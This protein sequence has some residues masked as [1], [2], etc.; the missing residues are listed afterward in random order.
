MEQLL[1]VL[2]IS[3]DWHTL[4]NYQPILMK[5]YYQAGLREL[6]KSCGF[7]SA[8]LKSLESCSNFKRTHCFL[9]QVWE[10]VY[11]EIIH[12][13]ISQANHRELISNVKCFLESEIQESRSP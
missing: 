13:Y 3:E 7:W 5:V 8:T 9:L 11:R 4:K 2:I 10:E 1:Q 12:T 6:A